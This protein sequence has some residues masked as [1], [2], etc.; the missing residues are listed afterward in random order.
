VIQN[1]GFELNKE[2]ASF[3]HS[4]ISIILS[5]NFSRSSTAFVPSGLRGTAFFPPLP[6]LEIEPF[7]NPL[8][9]PEDVE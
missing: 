4:N 1:E 7:L 5:I 6:L 8:S 2:N 9:N 3:D